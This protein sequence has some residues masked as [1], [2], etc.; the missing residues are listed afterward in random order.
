MTELIS[1]ESQEFTDAIMKIKR[2]GGHPQVQAGHPY[3]QV[4]VYDLEDGST[5]VDHPGHGAKIFPP[6][7]DTIRWIKRL[8]TNLDG[9]E[10]KARGEK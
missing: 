3:V 7:H 6:E 10:P 5:L 1:I 8:V 4:D 9:S 2:C